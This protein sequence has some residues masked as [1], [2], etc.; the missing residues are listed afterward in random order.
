MDTTATRTMTEIARAY[1]ERRDKALARV[2]AG[3]VSR[4]MAGLEYLPKPWAQLNMSDP[5][6]ALVVATELGLRAPTEREVQ[7]M[8]ERDAILR[9][10]ATPARQGKLA[11]LM[12]AHEA[13]K[14]LALPHIW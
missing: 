9:E 11:A 4:S 13:E 2:S 8:A 7:F 5:G 6:D 10:P 3:T 14:A 1:D 12:L